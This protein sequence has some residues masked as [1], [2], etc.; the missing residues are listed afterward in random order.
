MQSLV[1]LALVAVGVALPEAAAAAADI[2]VGQIVNELGITVGGFLK[3]V[4]VK[5]SPQLRHHAG[6]GAEDPAVKDVGGIGGGL[7]LT[8]SGGVAVNIGIGGEE[9]KSVPHGNHH[10]A[11]H[12][13]DAGFRKAQ[14]LSAYHRRSQQEKTQS[15]G[16]AALHH[17]VGIGIVFQAFG[18]LLAV[19]SKDQ[20]VDH[21]VSVRR[22]VKEADTQHHESIEP[23]PGLVKTFGD[24]VGGE[25]LLKAFLVLK[26]IVLLGVGHGAG[27]KPAVKH[28]R[29]AVIGFAIFL[30]D[31]LVNVVLV[32]I[33]N[34]HT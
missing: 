31:H 18:H 24:E 20:T 3:I 32:K 23:S 4:V 6:A 10:F 9:G 26:G 12:L 28:F 11:Q 7:N 1:S 19:F 33:G 14:I 5:F 8:G 17:F 16:T 13:T 27:F 34:F 15:I 22:L 29:G 21:H 25:V 2:P 30:N